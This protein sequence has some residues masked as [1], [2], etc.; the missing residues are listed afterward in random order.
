MLQA[1]GFFS[2]PA[3]GFFGAATWQAVAN[4]QRANS[5]PVIGIA[6]PQTRAKLT[7][8]TT[9]TTLNPAER[10]AKLTL[11]LQEAQSLLAK[12]SSESSTPPKTTTR[13]RTG[14]ANAVVGGLENFTL[15]D[16]TL[17]FGALTLEGDGGLIPTTNGVI[18]SAAIIGGN[19]DS[20]WQIDSETGLITPTNDGDDA[21]LDQG[22]YTLR[23]SLESGEES[24]EGEVVIE[25]SGNDLENTYHV[26]SEEEYEEWA[27]LKDDGTV[28]QF[29]DEEATAFAY[30]QIVWKVDQVLSYTDN[31]Y[32]RFVLGDFW[33]KAP[34]EVV[35]IL[36]AW[37]GARHGA[38]LD[39][40]NIAG[41]GFYDRLTVEPDYSGGHF[42]FDG[43]NR[44]SVPIAMSDDATHSLTMTIGK[45]TPASGGAEQMLE[46][47]VVFT[48]LPP[49]E[50]V[51]VTDTT[52]RPSYMG[53]KRLLDWSDANTDLLPDLS[54]PAGATLPTT[55]QMAQV[56]LHNGPN[57]SHTDGLPGTSATIHPDLNM[58][59]YPRDSGI[60][61]SDYAAAT[62]INSPDRDTYAKEL[63]QVGIDLFGVHKTAPEHVFMGAAGYGNGWK[64][65]I[66]FAATLLGD[67]TMQDFND[68]MPTKF[69]GN[70]VYSFGEDG[71]TYLGEDELNLGQPRY[72]WGA[73]GENIGYE[74]PYFFNHYYRDIDGLTEVEAPTGYSNLSPA[75]VSGA[76]GASTGA[77]SGN[78]SGGGTQTQIT[79]L[80]SPD[81]STINGNNELYLKISGTWTFF[82][83]TAVDNNTKVVTAA[84]APGVPINSGASAVEWKIS[85]HGAY[86]VCCSSRTWV[87]QN[88]AL[89]HI[90]SAIQDVWG[91]HYDIFSGYV[92]RW[93]TD[94]YN[95]T[96]L[97]L[98]GSN[99][100][101]DMWLEYPAYDG[102]PPTVSLTNPADSAT[103][104]GDVTI[105]ATAD[106]NVNA[107]VVGVEFKVDDEL[108]LD[109]LTSPYSITWDSTGVA[110]GSYD[111]VAVARDTSGNYAT[112]SV[113]TVDVNN[114]EEY[115]AVAVDNGGTVYGDKSS[116]AGGSASK[117]GT[118][119][120][121]FYVDEDSWPTGNKRI[122]DLRSTGVSV[123]QIGTSFNAGRLN[124]SWRNAANSS[125]AGR[126]TN[127]NIF[128]VRTWYHILL[129]YD[130]ANLS[131]Q[132]Y[133]T[134]AGGTES[135]V[136]IANS[137]TS[138]DFVGAIDRAGVLGLVTGSSV[139]DGF[140]SDLW[141]DTQ[142]A[143]DL[144]VEANRRHFVD[145]NGRPVNISSYG[146][147]QLRLNNPVG[148]WFNNTGS[149]GN[150][151]PGGGSLN[152]AAS[153]PSD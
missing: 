115:S 14:G 139:F 31:D 21:D 11:L 58:P 82:D 84:E 134:P 45:Q 41:Q 61:V 111:L 46:R 92:N 57:N 27:A 38:M 53:T 118:V 123:L 120:F 32:G 72:M 51:A 105:S 43:S 68:L 6:G 78:G 132:I 40:G 87:G 33:A 145:G 117:T 71:L 116:F 75:V 99:F 49:S 2:V 101:R 28:A 56:W 15:S 10:L 100:V 39:M 109:D 8:T 141:V 73:D 18:T 136:P 55:G 48:S 26:A 137:S 47:A 147:P 98:Y 60:V 77:Y 19:E 121:W 20:H 133:M 9:P 143:L 29:R 67:E 35:E 88:L 74:V 50:T 125:I 23:L 146:S 64:F 85:N 12:V 59:P 44:D 91:D 153:S 3:T 5:L 150:L 4:F 113:V 37:D 119:S 86:R 25:T 135:V 62:L 108:I 89:Y 126:D 142:N 36:P 102:T 13:H 79:L 90:G 22:P 138:N 66:V 81:L 128:S 107:G 69:G 30:N 140:M 112:S 97:N 16:Q 52:F 76:A 93:V 1:Q 54:L 17:N 96:G 7:T 83:I 110:D 94:D 122:L 24:V 148:S 95:P 129:S 65:P 149:G 127:T 70:T 106:D 152:A 80:G 131:V 42:A 63:I 124:F 34:F 103:V 114:T 151:T 130:L 144:S 104:L